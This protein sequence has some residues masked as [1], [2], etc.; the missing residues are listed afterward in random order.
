MIIYNVTLK[1][2][3]DVVEKWIGWMKAE[4]MPEVMH[5]GLFTDCRLSRLLEQDDADGITFSAQYFCEN[6]L[7]YHRYIDEFAPGLRDRTNELFGGK[8]VAFRSVMEVVE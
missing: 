3:T 7:Q 8:Y 5:T 4:H 1:V 2:D 6:L